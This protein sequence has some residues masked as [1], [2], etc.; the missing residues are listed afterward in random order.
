MGN[1]GGKFTLFDAFRCAFEGIA[2]TS[3]ERNFRIE[4][5]FAIAAIVLGVAFSI[6]FVEW[7]IVILFIGLVLS[8]EVLNSALEAIVDLVSPEYH[9]L[10]KVAKDCAAGAVLIL[11]IAAFCVGVA[12]YLP[13]IVELLFSFI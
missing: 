13:P 10:A 2:R 5:C 3:R 1:N 8:F 7:L 9:P 6:S 4:L 11:A 12:L